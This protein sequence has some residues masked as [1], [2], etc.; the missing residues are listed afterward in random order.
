MY[1]AYGDATMEEEAEEG[2]NE[3]TKAMISYDYEY[4]EIN[5]LLRDCHFQ[6]Q[7][8]RRLHTHPNDTTDTYPTRY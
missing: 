6:R 1:D 4:Q 3:E 7:R 2:E 8:R 5:A